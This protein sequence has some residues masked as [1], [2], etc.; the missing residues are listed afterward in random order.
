LN[1]FAESSYNEFKRSIS[2]LRQ[3]GVVDL[4]LDLRDNPGGFVAIAN[5]IID[6]FLEDDKLILF[7]KI[8]EGK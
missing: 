1:R 8:K 6:E 7:T 2:D 3:R 4:V 5:Q